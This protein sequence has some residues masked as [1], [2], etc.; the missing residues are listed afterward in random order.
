M[1][2]GKHILMA[3]VL[4]TSGTFL[5][6]GEFETWVQHIPSGPAIQALFRDVPMPGGMA[7][8]LRPPAESRPALGALIAR[9]PGDAMLYRLRAQEAEQSLD[10]AAAEPD[11]KTYAHLAP[12]RY[13]GEIDLAD[14]YHRRVRPSDELAVLT[15]AAAT[16]DDPLLAPTAQRGWHAFEGISALAAQEDLPQPTTE[17]LFRQWVAR[18]PTERAAWRKLIDY[19]SAHRQYAAAEAE[20]AKYGGAF[21]DDFEPVRMRAD[22]E[23]RRGSAAAA[24]AVYSRAFQPLWPDDLRA[25]YFK[26]LEE[27]GQLREFASRARTA[28]A[29][30]RADLDATA[31]LFHYFNA[32]NNP[33]AA[34]RVL[35][36]YRIAKESGPVPWRADE[37]RATAQLF[38]WLPDANEAARL[39]YALYSL[40]PTDGPHAERALY[41]L[42]HLLLTASGQPIQFGSG[43]LSFYKD[44]ATADPSPG[45]LNGILSLVLNSTGPRWEYQSQNQKSTAYFH[46]A[47]ACRLVSL[48]EQQFPQSRYREDLR[49]QL[50]SA[51]AAYGDDADAIHAGREYLTTFPAGAGRLNVAMRVSDALARASRTTEEFAIYTLMLRELSGRAAGVPIGADDS[52]RSA[53]YAQVLDKYLARLAALH[54]PLDALRVYRGEIDRNPNDAGLYQRLATF[55]EQHGMSREVEEIYS[56]AIAKFTDRSWYHKLARWYLRKKQYADVEKISREAIGVFSGTELERYFAEVVTQVH[57]D[58]ALY[59][60]LNLYAHERF[61]EDMAFVHNLFGAY[62]RRETYDAAAADRLL[63]QYWFYDRSLRSMLFERLSGSGR[64]DA[65][66]TEIRA[67]NPG[68]ADGQ[69]D[70]AV[71]KNPAAVQFVTEAEIWLSHF[72]AAAPSARALATAYPG[73]REVVEQAST[74]YR[75]LAAYDPR[76]TEIAVNL[77]AD[78]QR[79]DPRDPALL[80]RMGDILADRGLLSQASLYW[81]KM[82]GAQPRSAQAYLDT[83]T[84]YWDYYRYNDAL[85]WIATARKK[86]AD[87]FL[88]S[89]QAG[90][91]YEGK[92]NDAGAVREYVKGALHGEQTAQNRLLRLLNRPRSRD[93]VS[94]ATASAVV[95]AP[96]VE[97][98]RLRVAV[99][100]A[101][102]RRRD[103]ES[104]LRSRVELEKTTAGMT[105]LQQTARR[106]GFDAIE[107]RASA[108]LATITND[109]VDKLRLTLSYVRLLE[110]KKDKAGA[111]RAADALYQSHPRILGVVRGVVDFHVRNRQPDEAIAILL[112]AA[113]HARVDL[114]AQFTLEA[115]RIATGAGEFDRARTL[116]TTLLSADPLRAEYLAAMADTYIA[117]KDDRRFRDYQLATIQ[118]LKQSPLPPAERIDRITAIRRSLIPALDRLQDRA[119]AVDQYIEIVNDFPEDEAFTKEAA[120]YAVAHGQAARLVSF[121]RKTVGDAPRDS[122]WPVVLGRIETVVEDFP[123]AIADYDLAIQARPGRADIFEAKGRLEERLLRFEAAIKTYGRLYELAYRD[124]QWMIKIAELQAR[125]GEN[126]QAVSSLKTAIIG[127]RTETADSDMAIAER[128]ETWHLLPDAA[129]FAEKGARQAGEDSD[130]AIEHAVVYARIMARARRLDGVLSRLGTNPAADQRVTAAIGAVVSENYTPE[131]KGAFA[132]AL[133]AQA[134]RMGAADRVSTLLPLAT[135]AGLAELESRWRR[136]AMDAQA[137]DVDSRLVELQRQ[138]GLYAELGRYLEG[139]AT[140]KDGQAVAATALTEAAQAYVA[141]GDIDGQMR[142]MQKALSRNDLSGALLDRYLT[143]LT[144]LN[145][146]RLL[147]IIG[148]NAREEIRNQAVQ[149][150]IASS[151]PQLAYQ[152]VRARGSELA[153]VWTKAYAALSG[154]YFNDRSPA[155]DA[156]FQSALDT[157]T[158]GERLRSPLKTEIAIAGSLWFYYGAQYG[159]YL[160]AGKNANAALWMPASV[161]GAHQDPGAYVLLGDKYAQGGQGAKA[162]TE[163]EHA[164]ELDAN[165]GE[166]HDHIARVL[167]R[168]GRRPEAV[169]HWRSAIAAYLRIQGRGVKVPELYWNWAGETFA[170]IGERRAF[171]LLR[172]EIANLLGDY[173]QRNQEY[174]FTELAEPAVRASLASGEGVDWLTA[175][176][177]SVDVG[178][179]IWPLQNNLTDEQRL[180][181]QR[182]ELAYYSRRAAAAFGDDRE[183]RFSQATGARLQL[184]AMLLN[185]GDVK[186]AL[187][188]WKQVAPL[189]PAPPNW[190]RDQSRDEVEIRLAA[191]TGELPVL[192]E[193][194]RSQPEFAPPLESLRN[195]ALVLRSGGDLTGAQ[196]VLEFLYDREIG[197]GNLTSANFLGL[198]EVML[199]RSQTVSAIALLSRM[200]LAGEDG[201]E[202][203][204]PAA[205]LLAKYGKSADAMHFTRERIKETPWDTDAKL[206][207]AQGLAQGSDERRQLLAAIMTDPQAPYKVRAQA[208]RLAAPQALAEVS[209]TELGLLC[210]PAVTAGD[211]AKPYQVEARAAA[212]RSAATPEPRLRLWLEALALAPA[213]GSVRVG[214][215]QA[216]IAQHRDTLALALA[217]PPGQPQNELEEEQPYADPRR[218]RY[219]SP[220][221]A[222]AFILPGAQLTDQERAGIGES[223]ANAAER[224]DD[225]KRAAAYLRA[226]ISLS[227]PDQR[228]GLQQRLN[229]F[230]AEQGRRAK[231]IARQPAVRSVIEQDHVVRPLISRSQP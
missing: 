123:A 147:A 93:L 59:R 166:A 105:E 71:A 209:G 179:V 126:A 54:R 31:R 188:E 118:R 119:G 81:E 173:Y 97:A 95:A 15:A 12:D 34:R 43:D 138:R 186:G 103:L 199:Q 40:P 30:N 167:W 112:D 122:R 50:I 72:E 162:I 195:A 58:A 1:K 18:Y 172:G 225:L 80:A 82:P 185:S 35:L 64:L 136:E 132:L 11:W 96:S 69:I 99:L 42:A 10:F 127:A 52:P 44:I 131:E 124:P 194:Y 28:L 65:E 129:A 189:T 183:W 7:P 148:S 161:E 20:I 46:V 117:A 212:A 217:Q 151:Q 191:K 171:G 98:I 149:C 33:A 38:E 45:F 192:L 170:D 73:R 181:L 77:A 157:R 91:I 78:E 6:R 51:Y 144:R 226:A 56:T 85:R 201:L 88:Y 137:R 25:S 178:Q 5:I 180:T 202:A 83:A 106:L 115:G 182:A 8:I 55:L 17:A 109:P 47:A 168:E 108:R 190:S 177:N 193:R 68:M 142:V 32:Q 219:F 70:Q 198:A 113:K 229:G 19:L 207:L 48:L 210:S 36:E 3:A 139:Y 60:Q 104:L 90:A 143:L 89:Y 37:L 184:I 175:L 215:L 220:R 158:I 205:Q 134:S 128:L 22:L 164:L 107:E 153:P 200:A 121:Y 29:S 53:E 21:H 230:V 110:A 187:A 227:K 152:A 27:R 92:R 67:A 196:M 76:D 2:S 174:R 23:L 114:A 84:V 26:L 100:E 101:G 66:L 41:G 223:L 176:S 156:D 145:T 204:L 61:P 228:G 221:P 16:K 206:Y 141:E 57:P 224:I 102:Q 203:L 146:Q 14:F 213:D 214:A 150:A 94:R 197:S 87:P 62:T 135:S 218:S 4:G 24:L 79:A 222:V 120:S 159:D 169:T 116:L 140:R 155:I 216:A 63:R 49:A 86:F 154:Q 130:K 231:N 75:S 39:Y 163:F 125:S 208:A 13:A 74:L 211:A 165:R 111:A 9:T 133:I 160:S